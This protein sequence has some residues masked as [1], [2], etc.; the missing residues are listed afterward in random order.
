MKFIN[1]SLF[2]AAAASMQE[3]VDGSCR[4]LG[5]NA[6]GSCV[7]VS[8]PN[9]T[10]VGKTV[11]TSD[12]T[13][14]DNFL[15]IKYGIFD[16][17]FAPS[18]P[19]VLSASDGN[20]SAVLVNATEY[21]PECPQPSAAVYDEDCLYLNIF[22]PST[23]NDELLAVMVWIHGGYWV[24]D[25]GSN[26]DGT[27]L[28]G[29]EDVVVVTI[30]YRLGVFGFLPTG[31]DGSGG[32]NGLLDTVTALKWVKDYIGYFGGDAN[33]VTVFGESAGGVNTCFL[34]VLPAAN[35]LFQRAI[36]QSGQCAA[37]TTAKTQEESEE[38]VEGVLQDMN[39]T[40]PPCTIEDLESLTTEELLGDS[41]FSFRL[42]MDLAVL[43]AYPVDFYREG[44]INP[45]DMIIGA[46][47]VDNG[48]VISYTLAFGDEA[49][50]E[51]WIET[52]SSFEVLRNPMHSAV[53]F[54]DSI[55]NNI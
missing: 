6:T 11:T 28:A 31:P 14:V 12:G 53:D 3:G 50:R 18:Q 38:Q 40:S 36:L 4:I 44:K 8:D 20:G 48:D 35:G 33:R 21:G 52:Y 55:L 24:Q 29:S 5:A 34:S 23:Q 45:T 15:G 37:F 30:N 43:P 9:A 42:S 49:F 41:Y 16:E 51:D 39:C 17:R 54:N 26:F 10:F 22:S 19:L 7:Y 46:N 32:M 1:L 2:L 27:N 25:A 13:L 47:T